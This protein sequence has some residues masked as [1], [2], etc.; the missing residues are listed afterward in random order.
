[1]LINE[2][3]MQPMLLTRPRSVIVAA[4]RMSASERINNVENKIKWYFIVH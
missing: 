2:A 1:M 4:R 3:K